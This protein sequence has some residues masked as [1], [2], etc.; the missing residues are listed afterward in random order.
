MD[1]ATWACFNMESL[2]AF[3]AAPSSDGLKTLTK[4]QL[5]KVAEHYQFDSDIPKVIRKDD[6]VKLVMEKLSDRGVFSVKPLS[7]NRRRG[8]MSRSYVPS[9]F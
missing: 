4:D 5:V 7:A 2:S 9:N 3:L 8:R 6:L 1:W